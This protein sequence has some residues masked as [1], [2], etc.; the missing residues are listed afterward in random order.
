MHIS[1]WLCQ[2]VC[3]FETIFN[4]FYIMQF[5]G[6][7]KFLGGKEG[8]SSTGNKWQF[9]DVLITEASGQYPQSIVAQIWNEKVSFV[10][11]EVAVWHLNAKANPSAKDAG[12]YFNAI[13][14]WKKEQIG[15]QVGERQRQPVETTHPSAQQSAP[16]QQAPAVFEGGAPVGELEELPF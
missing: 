2:R 5:T 12:K 8:V 14:I 1:M 9:D 11:G 10:D 15:G 6:S 3:S 4:F 7:I 16:A 13:T